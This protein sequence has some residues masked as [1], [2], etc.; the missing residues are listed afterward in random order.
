MNRF[1]HYSVFDMSLTFRPQKMYSC[2]FAKAKTLKR[3]E[4]KHRMPYQHAYDTSTAINAKQK[5]S[6]IPGTF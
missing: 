4:M 1:Q 2:V 6:L 3:T 5:Y